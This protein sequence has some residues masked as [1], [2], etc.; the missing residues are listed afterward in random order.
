MCPFPNEALP[1]IETDNLIN[2]FE[3]SFIGDVNSYDMV[4]LFCNG[5]FFNDAET[6]PEARDH[7]FKRI[8]QLGAN[9]AVVESLPQYVTAEKLDHVKGILGDVRLGVFMGF[10]SANDDIRNIAINT[11][12]TKHA[13]EST[14]KILLEH[15]YIPLA[16][17]MIKPPF[18]TESETIDDVEDSVEYLKRLGVTYITLCPNRVAPNTTCAVLHRMGLYGVAWIQTVEE[19]LRI[20]HRYGLE[21]MVNTSE[22]KPSINPDSECAISC[23]TCR[24]VRIANI[25]RYLYSRDVSDI[26]YVTC[27]CNSRYELAVRQEHG[28]W[29]N[30]AIADRVSGFLASL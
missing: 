23:M 25:E 16:F 22:L 30:T 8:R 3:S 24:D 15:N 29:G 26:P 5:N 27:S 20:T 17:L 7:M 10:Q 19:I 1:G 11:T 14:T 13:F 2:Q 18:V 6:S 28:R 4:T 12:C 21:V 9:Y